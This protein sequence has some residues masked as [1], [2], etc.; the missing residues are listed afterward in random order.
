MPHAAQTLSN[1]RT[2]A[3]TAF[4]GK[5]RPGDLL[6]RLGGLNAKYIS[7]SAVL[8]TLED[9]GLTCD[10]TEQAL[11]LERFADNRCDDNLYCLSGSRGPTALVSCSSGLCRFL[12]TSAP[13]ARYSKASRVNLFQGR[14]PVPV[15]TFIP[16]YCC[17]SE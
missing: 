13:A 6:Q 8:S 10:A 16:M 11:I 12:H 9:A 17:N 15:G 5:H 14:G 3:R 2:R 1:L 7:L 4:V